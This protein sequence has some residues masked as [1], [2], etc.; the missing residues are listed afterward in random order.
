MEFFLEPRESVSYELVCCSEL[1]KRPKKKHI[2]VETPKTITMG[3]GKGLKYTEKVERTT[4]GTYSFH[5]GT[6]VRHGPFETVITTKTTTFVWCLFSKGLA[7]RESL[8]ITE[9]S[10]TFVN[11]QLEGEMNQKSWRSG[12]DTDV[13]YLCSKVISPY[14]R[15]VLHG[16]WKLLDAHGNLQNSMLYVGGK[17]VK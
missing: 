3:L 8:Q 15:G 9:M 12:R 4:E 7:K 5:K 10:G 1:E 17:R 13:A 11:G 16:L 6:K 14:K 2:V